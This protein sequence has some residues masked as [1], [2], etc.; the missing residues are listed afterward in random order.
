MPNIYEYT[1]YREYLK[2]E[3]SRFSYR[4]IA[5]RVGFKSAGHFTQIIKGQANLSPHMVSRFIEFL[6]L[7][8]RQAEYFEILVNFDQ[9]RTQAEKT[10]YYERI[11]TFKGSAPSVLTPDQYEFY[12]KWYYAVVRDVLAFYTFKGDYRELSRILNPPISTEEARK[13]IELLERLNLIRK[14]RHKAYERADRV[15]TTGSQG[16]N[17]ALSQYAVNM[18]DMAKQAIDRFPSNERT[19][20]WTGI[21]VSRETFLKIQEETRNFRKRILTMAQNSENPDRTYHFN[22]QVFPTSKRYENEKPPGGKG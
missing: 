13:A 10:R 17:L 21:T 2:A 22:I 7:K 19:I 4:F 11:L 8:K 15:I 12:R 18:M 3:H 16:Y 20:S 6:K 1:S 5:A 14:N 9:A